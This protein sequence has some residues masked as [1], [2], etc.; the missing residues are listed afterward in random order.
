MQFLKRLIPAKKNNKYSFIAR[1]YKEDV[2]T[3]S[4][5]LKIAAQEA[6]QVVQNC[7]S[8]NFGTLK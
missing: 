7:G 4:K 8:G 1:E 2:S 5:N 6:R 3:M